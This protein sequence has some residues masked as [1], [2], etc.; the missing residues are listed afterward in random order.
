[1]LIVIDGVPAY[2]DN[3]NVGGNALNNPLSAINPADIESIDIAKDAAATSLYG[4]RAANGVVFVTTR[5]G[6]LGKMKRTYNGSVAWSKAVHTADVLDGDQYLMIKNE[7]LVNAGTYDPL[8]NYYG[9]SVGPDGKTVRTNWFD[10]I[11]HTGF[12]YTNSLSISGATAS[13]KYYGSI[14]YTKQNG[15]LMGNDYYRKS[16]TFNIEHKFNDWLTVGNR[17]NYA[18]D[19]TSSKLSTGQGAT[20]SAANSV[21]YRM[22]LISAPIIGPYNKDGSYNYTGLNLGLMD[23]QGHLSSTARL[24]YTNPVIT[25]TY[26]QDNTGNNF[27]QS[28]TFIAVAPVKGVLLKTAY[29][30]DNMYSRTQRYFDPRSD[31]G[32]TAGGSATGI[33]AT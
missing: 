1:P 27:I 11:F 8:K 17:T 19:M 28:N 33:S 9:N 14:A 31:E 23:N 22:A 20:N 21:A 13:T 25:L 3:I 24:G 4:S 18:N 2:T 10:Y 15:I 5:K 12:S 29:G 32:Y 26:N 7:G 16:A 6:K 30:I